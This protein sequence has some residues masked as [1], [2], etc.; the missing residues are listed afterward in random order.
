[1][2]KLS[3]QVTSVATVISFFVGVT[4]CL[5][6]YST[7]MMSITDAV[8]NSPF[9]QYWVYL[10]AFFLVLTIILVMA[11]I[12]KPKKKQLYITG[13]TSNYTTYNPTTSGSGPVDEYVSIRV[14]KS[15]LPKYQ[16]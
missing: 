4:N 3:I 11:L 15:E 14:K 12:L 9:V 16:Q 6:A 5:V 2:F 8:N 1:M 7:G 10:T 13:S